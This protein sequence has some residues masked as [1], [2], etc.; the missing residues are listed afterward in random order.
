[1]RRGLAITYVLVDVSIPETIAGFYTLSASSVP[2]DNFPDKIARRLSKYP[3]IPVSLIGR[4]ATDV[5]YQG[6]NCGSRL[7]VDALMRSCTAGKQTIGLY[8]V[9]VEAKSETVAPFYERF[10]FT[11]F[12]DTDPP[13]LFL[14]IKTARDAV[15]TLL[16]DKAPEAVD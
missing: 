8:A 6:Q 3:N 11:R 16:P 5:R 1:M 7:V 15:Q 9:V 14:P 13:R 12:A 2:L 10:G 4:L